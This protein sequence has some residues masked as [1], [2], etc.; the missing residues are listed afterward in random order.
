MPARNVAS[1]GLARWVM[2]SEPSF[3]PLVML[4]VAKAFSLMT[5]RKTEIEL[6]DVGVGGEFCA[7]AVEHDA[8]VLHHVAVVGERDGRRR[9][10]LDQQDGDALLAVDPRDAGEQLL[11]D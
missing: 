4:D 11:G 10:L 9:V 2:S 3:A 5:D 6:A 1:R 7:V 8:A